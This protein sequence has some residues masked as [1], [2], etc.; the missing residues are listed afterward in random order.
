MAGA[1]RTIVV[2]DEGRTWD[3]AWASN[4]HVLDAEARD[5]LWESCDDFYD[6]AADQPEGVAGDGVNLAMM[7]R[8]VDRLLSDLLDDVS[9][10]GCFRELTPEESLAMAALRSMGEEVPDA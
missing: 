2:V 7:A 3:D 9:N 5:G 6:W 4:I 1:T 8:R 10:H